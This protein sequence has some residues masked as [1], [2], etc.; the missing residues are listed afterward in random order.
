MTQIINHC[1]VL[2]GWTPYGELEL[3]SILPTWMDA[4]G[5]VPDQ[6]LKASVDRAA[7]DHD[8]SKPFPVKLIVAAYKQ[9]LVE[10]RERRQKA[11]YA[12]QH[13]HQDGTVSCHYCDGTGYASIL[14]YCGPWNDWRS[15]AYACQCEAAPISQRRPVHIGMDWGRNDH[16]QWVPPSAD[17]SPRC[18]CLFCQNERRGRK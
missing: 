5:E 15:V 16:G 9:V 10:D 11:A 6:F 8:W 18:T 12:E 17:R 7:A 2:S 3:A 14:T 13:R 1:R 4:L